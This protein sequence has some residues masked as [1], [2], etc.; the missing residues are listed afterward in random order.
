MANKIAYPWFFFYRIVQFSL[1]V[2]LPLLISIIWL[3]HTIFFKIL[4][5]AITGYLL[6]IYFFYRSIKPLGTILAKVQNF[7][8]NIPFNKTLSLL[9][10]KD[11]WARVEEA[12]NKAEKRLQE[13]IEQTKT[14]ND[15]IGAILESIYDDIIAIDNFESLLFYNSNFKKNFIQN[16]SGKEIIPKLWHI[17]TDENVLKAFRKVLNSGETTILKNLSF[18]SPNQQDR[19][20]DLTITPLVNSKNEIFG[21]LGVF[22]DV[23]EFKRTEQM[24]VDFVANVSHEIRTPLTSIKG[25]T[26]ILLSMKEKIDPELHL[27][28]EKIVSNTER[29]INLFNDL[30]HLSVIESQSLEKYDLFPPA[31]MI[32]SISESIITNY[33]DKNIV[34]KNTTTIDYIKGDQRLIEQVLNNL[35]DNACK[36]SESR[37]IQIQVNCYKQDSQAKIIVSDNGPGIASE[38]LERIFERFYRVDSS[39][40]TSRGTGLGLSI[41]KHIINKHGGKIWAESNEQGSSFHIE[42]PLN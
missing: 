19:F 7:D 30:L 2:F 41:V 29:M 26:Q 17:F 15:K 42:L 14:E 1:L 38:H 33:Q 23:T 11:E 31:P 32:D 16:K 34:I 12:L 4:P 35:L 40:G 21:A 10:R 9:Y 24:R 3:D 18:L 13:Q 5:I 36:Y 28:L 8:D 6:F 25:Y 39:R 22:Y 27:F 37:D 20:F